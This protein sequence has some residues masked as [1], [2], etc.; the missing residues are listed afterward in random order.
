MRIKNSLSYLRNR[1]IT[2]RNV[3]NI[4]SIDAASL[5]GLGIFEGKVD[6]GLF[7]DERGGE[8]DT[9]GGGE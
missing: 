3:V 7:D 5:D 6:G 4:Q 2:S 1:C 9:Q 8:G